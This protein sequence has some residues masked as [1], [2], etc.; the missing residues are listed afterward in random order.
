MRAFLAASPDVEVRTRL[1]DTQQQLKAIVSRDRS[2]KVTWT[3]PETIHLTFKFFAEL[4]E[5]VVDSL[6]TIGTAVAAHCRPM[7]LPLARLGAFPKPQAPRVLW[8]GAP[9]GW[10]ETGDGRR[11]PEFAREI[12]EACA[13]LGLTREV[14]PWRPHV[15]IARVKEGERAVGRALS[16][17]DAFDQPLDLGALLVSE[18][19][20]IRSDAGRDGHTHTLLWSARLTP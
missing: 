16:S 12:D 10:A 20:L 5:T 2:G 6:R 17:A 8:I 19:A 15:T 14:K 1:A 11:L 7:A 9:P 3:K 18:I 13:G 4:D